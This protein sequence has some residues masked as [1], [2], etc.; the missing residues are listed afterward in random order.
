MIEQSQ[1][2]N[3]YSLQLPFSSKLLSTLAKT[4]VAKPG[5]SVSTVVALG[6]EKINLSMGVED[7]GSHQT[8]RLTDPDG[9][10]G[11]WWVTAGWLAGIATSCN[12]VVEDLSTQ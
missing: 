8:R 9:W 4:N 3:K 10:R 2:E 11:G 7:W 5:P 6:W 12:F 1:H